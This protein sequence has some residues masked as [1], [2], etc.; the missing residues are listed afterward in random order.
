MPLES[1]GCSRCQDTGWAEVTTPHGTAVVRCDCYRRDERASR[2]AQIGVPTRFQQ[3]TFDNFSAGSYRENRREYNALT[4]AM[5]AAKRFADDYPEAKRKGLLIHGGTAGR[6]THLAVAT[7]KLCADHGFDC[8]FFNYSALL[9]ALMERADPNPTV[10]VRSRELARRLAEVDVLLLDSMGEHRATEWALDLIGSIVTQRYN[11]AKGLIATTGLALAP[12]TQLPGAGT[13]EMRAYR[14]D[15]L[16]NRIGQDC[17]ARLLEHCDPVPMQPSA[18]GRASRPPRSPA[19]P[20]PA[21]FGG[22]RG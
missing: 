7:L 8:L 12:D 21:A 3:A 15:T 20:P 16:G 11:E 14:P 19:P 4:A 9:E 18:E 1:A 22:A 6:R 13:I 5:F 10:A 2:Y 17:L